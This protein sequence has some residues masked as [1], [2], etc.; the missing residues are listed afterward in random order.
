MPESATQPTSKPL[1]NP[2]TTI[3]LALLAGFVISLGNLV[4]TGITLRNG[5]WCV[6]MWVVLGLVWRMLSSAR[7]EH[8]QPADTPEERIRS[9]GGFLSSMGHDLRQPAQAIALF[10]ATLSAHP[11]PDSS[12]KLV[13]G[14]ESAVQQLS[15]QMEAVFAI[16]KVHAG[17]VPVTSKPVVL[18]ELLALAVDKA[19]DEAHEHSLHIRHVSTRRQVVTDEDILSRIIDRL[20]EH[21]LNATTEGGVVAGCRRHGDNIRVEVWCSSPGIPAELLDAVFL[22][23]SRYGQQY[24]D[25][26]LGLVLAHSL[27]GLINARL[28]VLSKDGRGSLLRLTLPQS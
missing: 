20:V 13:N 11:L 25:R 21:A 6:A 19:L 22:A 10:A 7:A 17:R 24:P 27:A 12:R 14:I 3:R 26:G 16:A 28:E 15:A 2:Y 5:M 1:A 4:F 18:E 9:E 8:G 23:G